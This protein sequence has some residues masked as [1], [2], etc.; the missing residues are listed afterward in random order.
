VRELAAA[1][2]DGRAKL[3][4]AWRALALRRRDPALFERGGYTALAVSGAKAEHVVAFARQHEGRIAIAVAGRL[5]LQLV[6]EHG[7]LPIGPEVWQ[8]TAIELPATDSAASFVNVLT[9]ETVAAPDGRLGV[10]RA[11]G[12]FPG[13]LLVDRGPW[14]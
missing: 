10:G 9:G 8:D 5:F 1:P 3:W 13:A 2:L 11:F 14:Q 6:G 12:D 4:L 7:R